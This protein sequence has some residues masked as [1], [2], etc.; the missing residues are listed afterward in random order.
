MCMIRTRDQRRN[1]RQDTPKPTID[2]ELIREPQ[3]RRQRR[4]TLLGN[5][6]L[7]RKLKKRLAERALAVE[8]DV[9]LY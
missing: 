7:M 2:D 5:H 9:H 1:P 8:L 3:A 6:G 4:A